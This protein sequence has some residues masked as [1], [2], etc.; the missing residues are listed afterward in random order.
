[1]TLRASARGLAERTSGDHRARLVFEGAHVSRT[2]RCW[3]QEVHGGSSL[4]AGRMS[5]STVA[6]YGFTANK[7]RSSARKI[8]VRSFFGSAAIASLVL[9]CGWTVYAN[10]FAASPYPQLGS[11]NFDAP[12]IRRPQAIASAVNMPATDS[13]VTRIAESEPPPI[14]AAPA[15]VPAGPSLSFVDRFAAAAPQGVEP[16]PLPER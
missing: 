16:A 12:V 10:I 15:T 14:I 2:L 5:T 13:G 8:S 6:C 4:D 11:A 1:M 7:P 9:G 3:L